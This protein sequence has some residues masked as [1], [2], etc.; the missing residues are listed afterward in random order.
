L[1][2]LVTMM[3]CVMARLLFLRKDVPPPGFVLA[4][5]GF[6]GAMVGVTLLLAGNIV[7]LSA[8]QFQL[9]N[10]LLYE[11]MM[12][13][14]LLGVG[15]FLLPR[16]FGKASR[17]NLPESVAPPPGWRGPA[18]AALLCG[19]LLLG[20]FFLEAAGWMRWGR[21]I[22]FL[23]AGVYLARGVPF[24]KRAAVGSSLGFAVRV[25]LVSILLG[26]LGVAIFPQF[27]VGTDHLIY[28]SGFGL[29]T[30]AVSSRVIL[31]HSG[32]IQL[33]MQ[34]SRPMQWIVWLLV[35]AAL[36]R[37]T[38]DYVPSTMLSHHIYAASL[39]VIVAVIW[40]AWLLPKIGQVDED[41]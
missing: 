26:L 22:R 18:M 37:A 25:A 39:W 16:F 41:D 13:A 29:V 9:A 27:R 12:L 14:A 4:G 38:A 28:I 33:A 20:T 15:G 6:A 8:F 36:T 24:L 31:G 1:G 10:L 11:G 34:R 7:S 40:G 23:V 3:G 30:L 2:L 21:V 32:N 19:F 5:M 17:E 35:L